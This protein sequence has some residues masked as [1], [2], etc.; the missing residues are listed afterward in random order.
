M[1]CKINFPCQLAGK[2]ALH[3]IFKR[4]VLKRTP[5][6]FARHI[7]IDVEFK[8]FYFC[9]DGIVQQCRSGAPRNGLRC[10]AENKIE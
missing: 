8:Q 1:R 6:D 4:P 9:A 7:T 3:C 2:L 5:L 10:A